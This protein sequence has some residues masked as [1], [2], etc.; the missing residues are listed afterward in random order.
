MDP[1]DF[2]LGVGPLNYARIEAHFMW[3]HSKFSRIIFSTFDS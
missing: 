2:Y 1:F 3:F